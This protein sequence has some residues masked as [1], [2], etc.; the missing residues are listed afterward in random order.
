YEEVKGE[1]QDRLTQTR[2]EP[3]VRVYL[4][5]LRE[6]AFLEIKE[7][8]TDSGAAAAKEEVAARVKR[9]L[10]WVIPAGTVKQARPTVPASIAPPKTAA[11]K[12]PAPAADRPG[13]LAAVPEKK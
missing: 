3:K 6:D 9:P 10:R 8:Y 13:E 7:G 4:T 12:L 1:I 2:M 11:D 5:S